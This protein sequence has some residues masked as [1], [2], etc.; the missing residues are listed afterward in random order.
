MKLIQIHILL[1][2]LAFGVL[3]IAAC[4]AML[5][6]IQEH[7]LRHKQSNRF[8]SMLPAM[9]AMETFL[10]RII[11]L[12]F[13]LLTLVLITS[14][15]SFPNLLAPLLWQKTLLSLFAWFVFMALLLGRY[16]FGWRGRVAI[17]WTFIGV[18]LVVLIYLGAI[19]LIR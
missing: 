17:R 6:A 2:T 3:C 4:Q 12:G 19:F 16:H 9:Q 14:L 15:F 13:L 18:F 5:L 8:L 7:L 1:S 10:F 11:A